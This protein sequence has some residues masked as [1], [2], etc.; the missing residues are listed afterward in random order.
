MLAEAMGCAGLRATTPDEVDGVIEK[1]LSIDDR[2]VVAEFR[3][4]P[5]ESVFPMVPTGASNDEV[6]LGSEDLR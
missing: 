5:E 2:P 4:D 6:A 1:A 3:V